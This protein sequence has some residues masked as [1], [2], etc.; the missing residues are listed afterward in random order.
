MNQLSKQHRQVT[1]PKMLVGGKW[2]GQNRDSDT[3]SPLVD[4]LRSLL[5]GACTIFQRMNQSGDML[6]VT[7]NV[8]AGRRRPGHRH[9]YP[10]HR[11]R[12]E[13]PTPSSKPC[14][15]ARRF[16]GRAFVVNGWYVTAYEPI[17]D[18]HKQVV[19]LL[20][21]GVEQKQS[22]ELRRIITDITVG[23]TGYA[24]LVGCSG[25]QQGRYLLSYKGDRDGENIFDSQDP[26]GHRVIQSLIRRARDTKDG[27]CVFERYLWQNKGERQP[28]WKI[29][30]ATYFQPW[31]CVIGVGAYEADYHDGQH[32]ASR[33]PWAGSRWSILSALARCWCAA[34]WPWSSR[35][36]S[37]RPLVRTV[38]VMEDVA[39][40][41]Y[42]QRLS[43]AAERR[44]RA[45]GRGHQHG[46]GRHRQDHRPGGR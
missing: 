40:G 18:A 24:Y 25:N 16:V 14:C 23:K 35:D 30:A 13:T 46:R 12:T 45:A 8:K 5:G 21:V 15:A 19:G 38:A 9:L 26:D 2:L 31:D 44:G 10:R 36:A 29:A 1:L 27:Q 7:T 20:F 3:P 22:A 39:R 11:A 33:P 34:A 32:R 6:G 4:Q 17:F 42:T 41:D 28:R 37:P 43:V